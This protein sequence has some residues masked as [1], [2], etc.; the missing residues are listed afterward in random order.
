MGDKEKNEFVIS[1][2]LAMSKLVDDEEK[3]EQLRQ[4]ALKESEEEGKK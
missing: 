2:R 3:L 4:K 1:Q